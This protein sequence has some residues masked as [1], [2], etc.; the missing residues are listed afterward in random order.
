MILT[1]TATVA[2]YL[3]LARFHYRQ[4]K[5]AT[6]DRA[7]RLVDTDVTPWQRRLHDTRPRLVGVIVLSR[8]CLACPARH[9]A[10]ANRYR[11]PDR[12]ATARLINEEVRT[13][14]RLVI[15]P[16]YRGQGLAVR[17]IR[18][19]LQQAPT[20][21]T[22]ALAAMARGCPVFER[23]GM[24]RVET[25]PTPAQAALLDALHDAHVPRHAL[26]SRESLRAMLEGLRLAPWRHVE[27]ALRE[28]HRSSHRLTRAQ[29]DAA[30]LEEM[31]T[32]AQRRLLLRPVYFFVRS[33]ERVGGATHQ[34]AALSG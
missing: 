11:G 7:W 19:A 4:R 23:A 2:D 12:R 24:T 22:E 30:T 15:D 33:E 5:P 31:M 20:I 26:G 10:T 32:T 8:P 1:Q 14:S 28:L 13:I 9:V 27:G 18:H 16:A 25:P 6:I 34:P 21:H 3:T 17:L 29:A